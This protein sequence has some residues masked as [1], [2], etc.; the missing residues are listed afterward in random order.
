LQSDPA[1]HALSNPIQSQIG[2]IGIN[3]TIP[4][5]N[6]KRVRQALQYAVDRQRY[7]DS[8]LFKTGHPRILPWGP[9]SPAYQPDKTA[10]Y[11]FDL[12]KTQ[13][14]LAAAG[15]ADLA[16]EYTYNG[17]AAEA[18]SLAQIVQ[19]DLASIGVKVTLAPLDTNAQRDYVQT[20]KYK[21]LNGSAAATWTNLEG[22]TLLSQATTYNYA[23][24]FTGFKSDV[25]TQLVMASAVEPDLAKR[26]ELYSQ[27][28]DL[29]LD[30]SF[31]LV[32]NS[33]APRLLA[34]SS[35]GGAAWR[36]NDGFVLTNVT[37]AS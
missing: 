30:E 7:V 22:S 27:I 37:L 11:T 20:L 2:L 9:L 36:V 24:N 23:G 10:G 12:Q 35:V 16:L 6:D 19:S 32:V 25:Y 17:G 29:L 3:T 26:K 28:N 31:A 8:V 18:A 1:Y 21:G 13:A 5:L 4:P 34:R 33:T 14:M 15:A